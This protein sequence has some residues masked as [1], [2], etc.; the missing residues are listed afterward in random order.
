ESS[1]SGAK[2]DNLTQHQAVTLEEDN[3]TAIDGGDQ[4]A[5]QEVQHL[6]IKTAVAVALPVKQDGEYD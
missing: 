4:F 6:P 3:Q 2:G 5:G 1:D